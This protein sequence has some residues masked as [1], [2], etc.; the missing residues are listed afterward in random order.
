ME[1]WVAALA[2]P[3]SYADERAALTHVQTHISHVFLGRDRVYKL[4]KPVHFGFVDFSTRALRAEDCAREIELNQRL[5][6]SVYLGVARVR[7][8]GAHVDV[9][10]SVLVP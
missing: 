3:E 10:G 5:A 9:G 2:R 6:P 7:V 4:R 1:D 8:D